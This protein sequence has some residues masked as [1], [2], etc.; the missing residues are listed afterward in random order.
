MERQAAMKTLCI[1]RFSA[2][3]RDGE[4][5][6][7]TSTKLRPLP[8]WERTQLLL[9]V[10]QLKDST[11]SL[12]AGAGSTRTSVSNSIGSPSAS[13]FLQEAVSFT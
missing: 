12:G 6:P 13:T 9:F 3:Q 1:A 4:D 7:H 8:A 11:F 2:M 10:T 5:L